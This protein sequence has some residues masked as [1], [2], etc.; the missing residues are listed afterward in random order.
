MFFRADGVVRRMAITKIIH[1]TFST[2][3]ELPDHLKQNAVDLQE[4]N[5]DWRYEFYDDER[6]KYFIEKQCSQ[7]ILNLY[8]HI[9]KHYGAARADFFRYLVVYELGGVYLDIKSTA[10][11]SLTPVLRGI[12]DV[13]VLSHWDNGPE[14]RNP[15][16]GIHPRFGVPNEFQQWFLISPPKH[17][18]LA[19]VIDR[20]IKNIERYNA[21]FD[22]VGASGVFRATGPIAFTRAITDAQTDGSQSAMDD[23]ASDVQI[24]DIHNLGFRYSCLPDDLHHSYLRTYKGKRYPIVVPSSVSSFLQ[25]MGFFVGTLFGLLHT[26]TCRIGLQTDNGKVFRK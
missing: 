7:R 21:F 15:G 25:W 11:F 5:P 24:V 2:F 4:R 18:Y 3:D 13:M 17:P 8:E 12:G 10:L 6:C 1:Q 9:S 23:K 14:G 26:V 16:S 20:V 22:G 19:A